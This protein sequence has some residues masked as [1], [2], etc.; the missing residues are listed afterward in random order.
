MAKNK[1]LPEELIL[2][3]HQ[4]YPSPTFV[5]LTG[6]AL[7]LTLI[8]LAVF[9]VTFMA[10]DAFLI[11]V[12][13]IFALI[14]SLAATAM[15]VFMSLSDKILIGMGGG[16]IFLAAG[17]VLTFRDFALN[18]FYATANA[19]QGRLFDCGH[20]SVETLYDLTEF[21]EKSALS[22]DT[23]LTLFL[24]VL[25]TA[26]GIILT[27]FTC[28]R[29]Y[30]LPTALI[31]AVPT[32]VF[33]YFGLCESS[34]VIALIISSACGLITLSCY[35]SLYVSKKNISSVIGSLA[36][37]S[38]SAR[39][40]N[41]TAKINGYFGGY[42]GFAASLLAFLMLL[43]PMAQNKEM[44][45]IPQISQPAMKAHGV[46]SSCLGGKVGGLSGLFFSGS[47]PDE[48]RSTKAQNITYTGT[49][50]LEV[51]ST[52]NVPVY[53]RQWTGVDYFDDGWHTVSAD[54]ISEYRKKF[55]GG[56][57][58]E[59]LSSELLR[60]ID[61]SLI[62]LPE[63]EAFVKHTSLGY[64]TAPVYINK[65]APT[66]ALVLTPSHADQK[67][68]FIKYGGRDSDFSPYSNY[69]DGIFSGTAYMF[70]DKYG[71]IS[72][73]P[74]R[75]D[76]AF[77]ENIAT[78]LSYF[79]EQARLVSK[80]RE[81]LA[82]GCTEK[83]LEVAYNAYVFAEYE[84]FADGYA[85][86]SGEAS[87][88][89][90]YIFN[91]TEDERIWVNAVLDNLALYRTYVHENY[92]SL[93]ENG[94]S[95]TELSRKII[96]AELIASAPFASPFASV[97]SQIAVSP[98]IS[99][100]A[101]TIHKNVLSVIEYLRTNMTYTLSPKAPS[102]DREY[103]N[104][105]ETFLFDT[106]EGYCAQYASAAVM[107][108]RALGIPARYAEGYVVSDFTSTIGE[109]PASYKAI[110][111]DRNGHAW[112][113]V[114]YDFYGW[115]QYEVTFSE[116]DEPTT[117]VTDSP[118]PSD[119]E[120]THETTDSTRDSVHT[121]THEGTDSTVPDTGA[122]DSSAEGRPNNV[123]VVVT[124][125]LCAAAI[126]VAVILIRYRILAAD[127]KF[128]AIHEAPPEDDTHELTLRGKAVGDGIMALLKCR[129]FSP[130]MGERWQSFSLRVEE[131]FKGSW[132]ALDIIRK[133]EFST[134]I[135]PR[136]LKVLIS[137]FDK[138]YSD[139]VHKKGKLWAVKFKYFI[140]S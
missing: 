111:R 127:K 34:L 24:T 26:V 82:S 107:L 45:D 103:V 140:F 125:C 36:K 49:P 81:M 22:E 39:E 138:L 124:L 85:L 69:Y 63:D 131:S 53:L 105:A 20:S 130:M 109:S 62:L 67:T 86:P 44:A 71:M 12:S 54:R 68:G 106:K 2:P 23:L 6:L 70:T 89:Y 99:S 136:E 84:P 50:V 1:N 52:L 32:A 93:C 43:F 104:G 25:I 51:Y 118:L 135:S 137:Y 8:F 41:Y 35:D 60:I 75:E 102:E 139:T 55:G 114:Y 78:F 7:R 5:R 72:Q 11:P 4:S 91:M 46:I 27:L 17:F 16:F 117:D 113:E 65:L 59:F 38:P 100:S 74:Y 88:S 133:C 123:G 98:E 134:G 14:V 21:L 48:D 47:I 29:V 132:A 101:V 83:E 42:A 95:F 3:E 61:S 15:G 92:L 119:S 94:E 66:S 128:A 129:G 96:M 31:I 9:S 19:W 122:D 108:L 56:F 33:L 112:V 57:S 73:I 64:I 120:E 18:S 76:E 115:V 30:M 79:A 80:A 126:A 116:S 58:P 110:V 40:L 121:T 90:R 13:P 87:L 77:A 10:A 97:S 37:G 28:K